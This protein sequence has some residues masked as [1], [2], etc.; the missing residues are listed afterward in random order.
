MDRCITSEVQVGLFSVN[1]FMVWLCSREASTSNE[2][3]KVMAPK[4]TEMTKCL[5]TLSVSPN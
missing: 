4:T 3:P 5:S 1:N 2:S